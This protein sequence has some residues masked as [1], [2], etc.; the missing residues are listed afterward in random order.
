MLLLAPATVPVSDHAPPKKAPA[1]IWS[2]HERSP[3]QAVLD[4]GEVIAPDLR[5]VGVSFAEPHQEVE[6]LGD[7]RAHA[8]VLN[9][10]AQ[11]AEALLLEAAH[12]V[13]G[14]LTVLFPALG[15]GSDLGEEGVEAAHALTSSRAARFLPPRKRVAGCRSGS[16]APSP[17][18]RSRSVSP[19]VY[20]V[21]RR[22]RARSSGTTNSMKSCAVP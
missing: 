13:E 3:D 14:Q 9:G 15:C 18:M 7:A 22:P 8:A 17:K 19:G 2:S 21:R 11:R 20:S 10:K 6:Q 1:A 4:E 16:R 5:L 12:F